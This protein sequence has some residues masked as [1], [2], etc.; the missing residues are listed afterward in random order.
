M[1]GWAT[2]SLRKQL[3][4]DIR[5]ILKSGRY[6]SISEFVSEAIRLRLEEIPHNKGHTNFLEIPK[7]KVEKYANT[8]LDQSEQIWWVLVKLFED[9]IRKNVN[10]SIEI[11]RELRNCR[12]LINFIRV[13]TCP[14]CNKDATDKKLADLQL[15]LETIKHDLIAEALSVSKNYAKDWINKIDEAERGKLDTINYPAPKFVPSLPKDFDKGWMRLTLTKPVDKERALEISKQFG[16]TTTF[17]N[18]LQMIVQGKKNL[19][20]KAVQMIYRLQSEQ[21]GQILRRNQVE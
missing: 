12:T 5:E 21:A 2:V 1:L 13:H 19:V 18:D 10:V 11:P 17:N 15:S 3:I 8:L 6:R 20:R 7:V 4:E 9:L 14:E 16:V